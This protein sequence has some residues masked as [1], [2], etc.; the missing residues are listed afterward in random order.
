MNI[1]M[2]IFKHILFIIIFLFWY[3]VLMLWVLETIWDDIDGMAQTRLILWWILILV[4]LV[5]Y[6]YLIWKKFN[7]KS[8]YGLGLWALTT[9]S[10][11]LVV[12]WISKKNNDNAMLITQIEKEI[13]SYAFN[14]CKKQIENTWIDSD[15][16]CLCVRIRIINVIKLNKKFN[17]TSEE[18]NYLKLSS[19]KIK[20]WTVKETINGCIDDIDLF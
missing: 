18:L 5:V 1:S 8:I 9:L 11:V 19:S 15:K 20:A 16:T 17:T 7:I 14:Q 12:M 3:L 13:S 4:S 10:I 2:R 6:R